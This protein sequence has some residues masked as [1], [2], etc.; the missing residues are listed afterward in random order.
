MRKLTVFLCAIC[1]WL[2][3]RAQ[4]GGN[5]VLK[6]TNGSDPLSLTSVELISVKDSQLVKVQLTDSLGEVWFHGLAP[7]AFFCRIS[8]A[9]YQ[10]LVT[11]AMMPASHRSLTLPPLQL[12]PGTEPLATVTVSSRKPFI[13]MLPDRTVVHIENSITQTGST[14]MEALEK[15][16]GVSVDRDGNIS[17]KGRQGVLVLIDNKP[18]YLN[19]AELSN[20]LTGM[21][22]AQV[23]QIELIDNPS[24]RND[25]AGSAGIIQIRTK[26]NSQN[27][28]N[29]SLT[30]SYIQGRYARNN[31]FL[32]LNYRIGNLNIFL[33]YGFNH[34]RNFSELYAFRTYFK[35]DGTTVSARLEQPSF[36]GSKTRGHTLNTGLDYTINAKSSVGVS[37]TGIDINRDNDGNNTARWLNNQGVPDSVIYTHSEINSQWRNA[38]ISVNYRYEFN[39]AAH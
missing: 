19:G 28:L 3:G 30:S 22:T 29:G 9:G 38:G 13:E 33:N 39:P 32:A 8:R 7:S 26:K 1:F 4:E 36:L 27:G 15:L 34:G 24:A 20:L 17:M 23:S 25:A 2:M 18:S 31:N 35:P 12:L 14:V 21:S 11:P 10:E 37:L 16:P 6:I 5:I